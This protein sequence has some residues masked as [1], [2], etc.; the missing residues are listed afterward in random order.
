M[1][2]EETLSPVDAAWLRMDTEPNP[3]IINAMI[4]LGGALQPAAL[5]QILARIIAFPRFRQRIMG[6]PLGLGLPRWHEDPLFDPAVHVHRMALPSP[7]G[8][9]ALADLVSEIISTPLDRGRPLW[10]LHVVEGVEP[11]IGHGVAL[12]ARVHHCLGDGLAL[13]RMLLAVVGVDAH[14]VDLGPLLPPQPSRGGGVLSRVARDFG[15]LS[16]LLTLPFDHMAPLDRPQSHAK[17]VAW[18]SGVPL[19]RVKRIARVAGAKA[20]DV[21]M[22][23]VTAAVRSYLLGHGALPDRREV[24]AIV[25]V[26]LSGTAD[27]ARLGNHFGLVF[28]PL[29]L[30][31]ES[32]VERIREM[33]RRMDSIKA[34]READITFAIL[35]AAGLTAA[36]VERLAVDVLSRKASLLV[37]NV[38]GPPSALELGGQVVESM[39]VWAPT[40]GH[41]ALGVSLLSYAGTLRM[42]VVSDVALVRDPG[43]IV[44]AFEEDLAELSEHFAP[45]CAGPVAGQ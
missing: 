27:N 36:R 4:G 6:A 8:A 41:V 35:G 33:K 32:P 38:A 11:P 23:S 39:T 16:K 15:A 19:D 25:P 44:R 30:D 2:S 40:A 10:E 9:E 18:S 24:H 12:L 22:A 45:R 43:S 17:R 7:G 5:D 21:L 3:V 13:V 31:L 42:S 34:S 26:L 37:T 20:N 14:A 1:R 28:A 29:P